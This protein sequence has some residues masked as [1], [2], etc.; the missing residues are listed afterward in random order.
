MDDLEDWKKLK[1]A[2]VAQIERAVAEF[3][4]WSIE[5]FPYAK[6]KVKILEDS[7]GS[8]M[9]MPNMAAK[10]RRDGSPDWISGSGK[11]V[12]EALEDTIKHVLD[13]IAENG[14]VSENDFEWS[15]L[16]DF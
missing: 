8:Y 15:A 16:E 6:I 2:K 10:R 1:I 13:S 7:H 5:I 11:S 9:G 3:R 14:A 4:V 12:A